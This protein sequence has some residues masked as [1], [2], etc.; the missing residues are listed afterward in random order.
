MNMRYHTSNEQGVPAVNQMSA[1]NLAAPIQKNN[2]L[3][4]LDQSNQAMIINNPIQQ[5]I[6]S[7]ANVNRF[8]SGEF[9][10]IYHKDASEES[11]N[12][13]IKPLDPVRYQNLD[14]Q[15]YY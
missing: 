7:Y 5:Q 13:I 10:D 1:Y 4:K 2:F 3:L 11:D 12:M 15:D 9:R 6:E 14:Y 8:D